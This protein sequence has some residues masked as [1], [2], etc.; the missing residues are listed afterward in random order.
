M[1]DASEK[2]AAEVALGRKC[3]FT[4]E[5]RKALQSFAQFWLGMQAVGRA[6]AVLQKVVM[7]IGW[8]FAGYLALRGGLTD[9]IR[10]L[11]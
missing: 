3:D 9:W 2:L 4:L 11:R 7:W 6:A 8:A 10:G 5:E 1:P